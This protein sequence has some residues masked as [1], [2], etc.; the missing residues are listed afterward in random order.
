MS[1]RI[2]DLK[3]GESVIIDSYTKDSK[4]H[5]KKLLAMGLTPGTEFTL[6]RI[7]PLGDPVE[8]LIRG[9]TLSLRKSECDIIILKSA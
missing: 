6:L 4:F 5:R 3:P 9:S 8:I 1:L 2:K 7:A